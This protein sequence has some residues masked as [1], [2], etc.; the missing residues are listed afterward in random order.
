MHEKHDEDGKGEEEIAV[1]QRNEVLQNVPWSILV[2]TSCTKI[3]A[4][5]EYRTLFILIQMICLCMESF[6]YKFRV[7]TT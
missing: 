5:I 2:N 6:D 3:N 4:D 7:V 1:L